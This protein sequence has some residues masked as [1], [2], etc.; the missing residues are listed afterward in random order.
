MAEKDYYK[1]LGI[2]KNA[3]ADQI[4]SAY[5]KLAKKYHPDVYTTKSDS[6]K[7]AAEA[8]FKEVQHAY[9][10]LSDPQKKATYDQ[11]GSEDGP[12]MQGGNPF[13][14][15]GFTDLFSDIFNVFSDVGGG[16]ST[17][18]ARASAMPGDDIEL[19]MRLDFKEASFG[20]ARDITFTRIEK[21]PVCSGSGAKV[22]TE[23]KRCTKCGGSGTVTVNQRTMFGTMQT[24][25]TCDL[26]NG[27]GE[28]IDVPCPE[29]AGKGRVRRSRTL[30]VNI[31]AGVDEGQ[32]LTMRGEGS[33]S[34]GNGPNGNLLI[35][36]SIRAHPLFKRDGFNLYFD[37]PITSFQAILGA[38]INI[39]TLD[40]RTTVDIPSGTQSGTILRI[41]GKGIKHLRKDAFGDLLVK[42][43]IDT[44]KNISSK[45]KKKLLEAEDAFADAKYDKIKAYNKVLREL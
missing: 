10:V 33:A 41:R 28:T 18:Q 2:D 12:T 19:T 9:D 16:R 1:V 24:M 31:P 42:V 6:E 25:R 20:A 3:D 7:K 45:Q 36:F 4:K 11:F 21:C 13:G 5:R 17:R 22:G 15:G 34:L 35:I 44:P 26:C 27:S 23:K 8:K 14:T 38:K 30:K 32:I 37:L 29:C 43:V 39:P 40:G